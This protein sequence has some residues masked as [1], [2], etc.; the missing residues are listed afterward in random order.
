MKRALIV[1]GWL[2][3]YEVYT[4]LIRDLRDLEYMPTVFTMH[5]L[6]DFDVVYPNER[7][8][9]YY[10]NQI[11]HMVNFEEYDLVIAHSMGAAIVLNAIERGM[12]DCKVIFIAPFVRG[13]L[14]Q[15]LFMPVKLT[16]SV[17]SAIDRLPN[18]LKAYTIKF[19][20]KPTIG[21]R[22]Y[23]QQIEKAID[24]CNPR[25]AGR[26]LKELLWN[27][28]P[29]V[30]T[31][32]KIYMIECKKDKLMSTTQKLKLI[33][34]LGDSLVKYDIIDTGHS[35]ML[36]NYDEFFNKIKEIISL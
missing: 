11:K 28:I 23:Y 31:F 12:R 16:T 7:L 4:R 17:L 24:K 34:H 2:H 32:R 14:T 30:T 29:Y 35:P 27:N 22:E 13:T 9:D 26:L 36:T 33:E 5:G 15:R 3:S 19:V 20:S 18:K 6:D 1:H 8:I 10:S 25:M 21:K